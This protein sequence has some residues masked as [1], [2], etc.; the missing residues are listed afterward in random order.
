MSTA[1]IILVGL[2]ASYP[3]PGTYIEMDFAAGPVGGAGGPRSV[4]LVGNKTTAGIATAD[5]VVYGPD[6]QTPVQTE[7]DVTQYFGAG[8]QLHRMWLRFSAIAGSQTGIPIYFIAVTESAGAAAALTANF[9]GAATT[10]FNI[11]TWVNDD[12][13]DTPVTNGQAAATYGANLVVSINSQT[14]WP[15][16]AAGTTAVIL[17]AKNKGPEGNWIP[18]QF[19]LQASGGV[20]TGASC[21]QLANTHLTSGTTADV[22]TTALA[23]VINRTDY[24][25][26]LADSDAGNVGAAVTQANNNAQ[27]TVGIRQ[28]VVAASA[29]TS[30]NTTTVATGLNSARAEYGWFNP[31]DLPPAEG[32]AILTAIYMTLEQGAA[33]GVARKNFSGFPTG[34]TVDQNLWNAAGPFGKGGGVKPSRTTTAAPTTA[35]IVSLL[36]NGVTPVGVNSNGTTYIVKRCTTRSLSGAN[37][38]Y[39]IRDAH[40][41][42]I[43]D[44]WCADIAAVTQINFAGK[45]LLP[46]PLPGQPAFP[47]TATSPR[48]WGSALKDITSRYGNAGQWGYQPGTTPQAGQ[49]PADA[50]NAA[51][52]IQ[53][54]NNPPTRMSAYFPL[55]PCNIFDQAAVLGQQVA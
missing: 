14:R 47:P 16:T 29:D 2:A 5:T 51:A 8:S 9:T 4:L 32:A 44:Y 46:D 19:A 34:Q 1:A 39:R 3:L 30:A 6:T 12:F 43:C 38:D 49:S 40:K 17:T 18:V 54:E 53:T 7:A 45:D 21:N 13:V 52:I 27:P 15:V 23:T 26:V 24:Y 48:L 31:T 36:N 28:R 33:V 10:N 50:I 20:A 11:R 55:T 35:T 42:S 41:V 37:A 25:Q 22:N